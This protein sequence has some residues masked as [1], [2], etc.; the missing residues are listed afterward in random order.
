MS[1]MRKIAR[2]FTLASANLAGATANLARRALRREQAYPG[3]REL[4]RRF[5]A[6]G[7]GIE[8]DPIP[9]EETIAVTRAVDRVTSLVDRD[10]AAEPPLSD[11][12]G[13]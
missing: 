11:G 13:P 12:A 5:Y 8:A 10:L 6:A 4:I 9:P 3:L 1:R 7:T 2:P